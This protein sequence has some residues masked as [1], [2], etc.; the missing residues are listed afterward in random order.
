MHW[1]RSE[2]ESRRNHMR[3]HEGSMVVMQEGRRLQA[4]QRDAYHK[5]SEIKLAHVQARS[6][7]QGAELLALSADY[8]HLLLFKEQQHIWEMTDLHARAGLRMGAFRQGYEDACASGTEELSRMVVHVMQRRPGKRRAKN[9]LAH[10][11][12]I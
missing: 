3:E 10:L 12:S 11:H 1:S 2:R 6:V 8:A 5:G 4:F 9:R 7:L